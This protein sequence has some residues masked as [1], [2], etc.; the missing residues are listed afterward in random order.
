[1]KLTGRMLLLIPGY[2]YQ[3]KRGELLFRK[4]LSDL[5]LPSHMRDALLKSYRAN[6]IKDLLSSSSMLMN[7]QTREP[8]A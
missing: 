2:V 3:K 4:E 7:S 6:G 5:G 1:M 8:E